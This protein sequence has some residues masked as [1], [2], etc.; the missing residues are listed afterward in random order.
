[1][2][3]LPVRQT[4]LNGAIN[5]STTTVVVASATGWPSSGQY[6]V[7]IDNEI[8]RVTAGQGTTS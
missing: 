6:L 8:M 1:M 3:D 2:N 5:N 4:T 7:Q